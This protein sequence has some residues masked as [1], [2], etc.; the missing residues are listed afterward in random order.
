MGRSP[1]QM[2]VKVMGLE[3]HSKLLNKD[4]REGLQLEVSARWQTQLFQPMRGRW[5][6]IF[7]LPINLLESV[8]TYRTPDSIGNR[9]HSAHQQLPLLRDFEAAADY[10]PLHLQGHYSLQR[11]RTPEGHIQAVHGALQEA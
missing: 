2:T 10:V 5:K 6:L 7:S 3:F 1:T 11:A 8:K 9:W 4:E